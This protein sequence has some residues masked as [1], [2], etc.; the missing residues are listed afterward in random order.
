MR[1]TISISITSTSSRNHG[2][3][4]SAHDA[5][6]PPPAQQPGSR[7]VDQRRFRHHR[8]HRTRLRK[9]RQV[10]LGLGTLIR[11]KVSARGQ[12]SGDELLTVVR[13][14]LSVVPSALLAALVDP[15]RHSVVRQPGHSPTPT[16]TKHLASIAGLADRERYPAPATHQQVQ[17]YRTDKSSAHDPSE[18][19]GQARLSGGI[20]PSPMPPPWGLSKPFAPAGQS[21]A[22]ASSFGGQYSSSP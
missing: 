3:G 6:E 2:A 21:P 17:R 19:A 14:P 16:A 10:A 4:P 22:G 5:D 13:L 18:R 7:S 11:H 15:V 9:G 20:L 8:R 12:A 1:A